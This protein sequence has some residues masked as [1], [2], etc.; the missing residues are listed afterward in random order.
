[1]VSWPRLAAAPDG[2]SGCAG[3]GQGRGRHVWVCG[4]RALCVGAARAGSY[5]V[6]AAE[7]GRARDP[8]WEY[9]P[10]P[11]ER[12]VCARTGHN[13][14]RQD[15]RTQ[16]ARDKGDSAQRTV[17]SESAVK[18]S[19]SWGRPCAIGKTAVP[20]VCGHTSVRNLPEWVADC[21]I[22]RIAP[23]DGLRLAG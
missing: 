7:A 15:I 3:S 11:T 14:W 4:A 5:A 21:R 2:T 12:C 16:K 6:T 20:A 18:W 19:E 8:E 13:T 17:Q 9:T 1:M 23:V 22:P 10:Y